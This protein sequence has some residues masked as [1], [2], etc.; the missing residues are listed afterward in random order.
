MSCCSKTKCK[1]SGSCTCNQDPNPGLCF[2]KLN[3]NL[4]V[5]E[6]PCTAVEGKKNWSIVKMLYEWACC[7]KSNFDYKETTFKQESGNFDGNLPAVVNAEKAIPRKGDIH[8]ISYA[9]DV[10]LVYV[11]NGTSWILVSKSGANARARRFYANLSGETEINTGLDMSYRTWENFDVFYNGQKVYCRDEQNTG[12]SGQYVWTLI[13]DGIFRMYYSKNGEGMAGD[14]APM[15]DA[16]ILDY[17]EII[18]K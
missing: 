10:K 3:C 1:K 8:I 13:G 11:Y 18:E 9:N 16:L 12:V 6:L 14:P 15:G 7:M 17:L 2:N 5:Y 4:E